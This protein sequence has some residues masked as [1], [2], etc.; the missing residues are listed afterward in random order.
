MDYVPPP[1]DEI[2]ISPESN[3]ISGGA[4]P[5][6]DDE[7]DNDDDISYPS[8]SSENPVDRV[9][10]AKSSQEFASETANVM[11]QVTQL[12]QDLKS[13]NARPEMNANLDVDGVEEWDVFGDDD[14][15][16]VV[17]PEEEDSSMESDID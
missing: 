5:K 3:T 10:R 17:S 8:I 1:E 12:L 11:Q 9:D 2:I 13:S 7:D 16:V 15:D 4:V 6:S 14:E